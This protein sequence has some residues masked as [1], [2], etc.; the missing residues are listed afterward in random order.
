[1]FVAVSADARW[2]GLSRLL[3]QLSESC[4]LPWTVEKERR[5]WRVRKGYC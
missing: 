3:S 1:L 5:L 4:L 2:R